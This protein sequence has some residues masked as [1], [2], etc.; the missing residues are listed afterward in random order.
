MYSEIK[1]LQVQPGLCPIDPG[2]GLPLCPSPTEIDCVRV[3]KI[4]SQCFHSQVEEIE[5][6]FDAPTLEIIT[7]DAQEAECVSSEITIMDCSALT[8]DIVRIIFLL[9]TTSR[10]P[11]DEGGYEIS[12]ETKVITKHLFL[13]G[14]SETVL[15]LECQALP[16]CLFCLI[17]QRDDIGN[18]TQVRCIVRVCISLKTTA[19]VQLLIPTYGVCQPPECGINTP[20][21]PPSPPSDC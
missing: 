4:F 19:E 2:T 8:D 1:L 12:S 15:D 3:K 13:H 14:A 17:T 9:E 7:A 18:V 5:I 11:L 21:C 10:V 6:P 20:N 16:E